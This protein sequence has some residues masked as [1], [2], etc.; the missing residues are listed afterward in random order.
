MSN[1]RKNL[2]HKSLD[3]RCAAPDSRAMANRTIYTRAYS[4]RAVLGSSSASAVCVIDPYGISLNA[5]LSFEGEGVQH[6]STAIEE[7]VLIY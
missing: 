4:K 2:E 3:A 7:A 6:N 1:A 5:L